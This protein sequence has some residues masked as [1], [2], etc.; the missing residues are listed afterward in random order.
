MRR[1]IIR[2]FLFGLF[3]IV[4]AT[5]AVFFISRAAGDPLELYANSGYGISPEGEIAIRARLGLDKPVVVQYMLWLGRALKGDMGE[6]LLDRKPV[7]RVVTARLPA[8]VELGATAYFLSFFVGIPLGVLSAVKRGSGWDYMGR[9]FALLGQAVPQFWLGLV[10]ILLFA[11]QWEIFPAALR[12]DS[13]WDVK[14]LVLPTITLAWGGF[15][16]YTRI[17]RSA[18]LQILDSEY[19]RLARAKGVGSRTVIWKHA[20]R[21]A[22]IQPLTGMTLGLVGLLNGAVLTETIFAW[23]GMGDMAITA[24]NNNDFPVL[25][26]VV[27]FFTVLIVAMT[28]VSDL[29]YAV[30]DP[31]IRY[32]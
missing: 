15:A 28:F 8:T 26:A 11:V 31:R 20:F 5:L 13:I 23:P 32:D 19:I 27:F 21:N 18:M 25:Q 17:T 2:R 4:L 14:H 7:F 12:G 24:V 22:L 16:F 3:S 1:F 30:I 6:T 9:F 10:L 29:A